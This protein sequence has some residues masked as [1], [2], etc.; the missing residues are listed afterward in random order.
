MEIPRFCL[1]ERL[2]PLAFVYLRKTIC[3]KMFVPS[4]R[5]FSE[6]CRVT[7]GRHVPRVGTISDRGSKESTS[8]IR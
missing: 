8:V 5:K 2:S 3:L 4:V 7:G 1:G 6:V